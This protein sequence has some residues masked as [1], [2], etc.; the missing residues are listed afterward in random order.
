[1]PSTKASVERRASTGED[2]QLSSDESTDRIPVAVLLVSIG[3]FEALV[4]FLRITLGGASPHTDVTTTWR[5]FATATLSGTPLYL[6]D[7]ADN[8]PPLFEYLNLVV[9]LTDNYLLVFLVVVGL[10]NGGIGYLLWRTHAERGHHTVGLGVGLVF[11][12]AVPLVSGHAVNVRTF[13]LAGVLLALRYRSAAASGVA[14]AGAG[15]MSQ[16]AV[17]A[18]PGIVFARLRRLPRTRWPRWLSRFS[19]VAGITVSLCYLSVYLLWGES[20]LLASV[21]WSVSSAERYVFDWTPSLWKG[22]KTWVQLHTRTMGRIAVL[23]A[24]GALGIIHTIRGSSL[25]DR[26]QRLNERA[27]LLVG[28]FGL[29]L[30]VRPFQTYWMYP[31]PWLATLSTTGFLAV[32]QRLRV[33]DSYS[34]SAKSR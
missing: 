1:M 22:T 4:R 33:T 5:P 2:R 8:K 32:G 18:L 24:F 16:Y 21:R 7:V 20:S 9:G 27:I 29:P 23:L 3:V 13:M 17:F 19:L 26:R 10:V 15:L 6:A 31:L 25:D 28:L 30:F 11:I 14:I 12:L 34:G